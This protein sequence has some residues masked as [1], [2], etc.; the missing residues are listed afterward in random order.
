MSLAWLVACDGAHSLARH[1]LGM[2]FEGDTLPSDWVLADLHLAGLPIPANEIAVYWHA[3]GL[4]AIF[5][6]AAGRYRV[7]ADVGGTRANDRRVDPT[8]EQIQALLDERGAA[9]VTA[10]S[11]IW[12]SAFTINER[13]VASYRSDRVFLAGDAA[14]IHSPAGGQGMNTG[15][16]DACN[17]AWKLALAIRGLADPEP[18]LDSYSAERSEVGRQVLKAAGAL[19]AV[20]TAKGRLLQGLRN[21]AAALAFGLS[22]VRRAMSNAMSELSIGYPNGPLTTAG[23]HH[24]GPVAGQR[25]PI[26]GGVPIG[27]GDTPRFALFA[28]ASPEGDALIARYPDLLEAKV[29]PALGERGVWLVRPDGYVAATADQGGWKKIGAALEAIVGPPRATAAG[30]RSR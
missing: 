3:R 22:P 25:A 24:S 13:K 10:S 28:D 5:P 23:E 26:P 4:L 21:H 29:R 1:A 2:P 16:Q 8:L 17:L 6:I 20:A 11:A 30:P 15:M 19:T 18:L 14:H 27:A 7:I 12:L 9:G